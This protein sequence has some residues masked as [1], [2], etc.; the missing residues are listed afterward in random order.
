MA[1]SRIEVE[2][3]LYTAAVPAD[4]PLV[5]K[6]LVDTKSAAGAFGRGQ[7]AYNH[8]AETKGTLNHAPAKHPNYLPVWD[9][10]PEK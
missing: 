5:A 3:D 1:P 6:P 4:R 2:R 8:E 7:D 10:K 9:N